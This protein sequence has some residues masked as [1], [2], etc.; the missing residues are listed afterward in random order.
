[1]RVV[2]TIHFLNC[3]CWVRFDF[4]CY[5]NSTTNIPHNWQHQM[6]I[7]GN[8]E[9]K[10]NNRRTDRGRTLGQVSNNYAKNEHRKSKG[11]NYQSSYFNWPWRCISASCSRR[12]G[13]IL[14]DIN[15][16]FFHESRQE[17]LLRFQ[18]I[19]SDCYT[20]HH[21]RSFQINGAVRYIVSII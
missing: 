5:L 7:H 2:Q 9:I 18:I 17:I 20:W 14:T 11:S 10:V 3:A 21:Q 6:V 8:V 12:N 19:C 4:S 1:M 16:S 13:R 15:H